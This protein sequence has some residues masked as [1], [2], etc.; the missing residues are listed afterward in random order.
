MV[1]LKG[2]MW[3]DGTEGR[4]LLVEPIQISHHRSCQHPEMLEESSRSPAFFLKE[5]PR[6]PAC[7][8]PKWKRRHGNRAKPITGFRN[9]PVI[10]LYPYLSSIPLARDGELTC[11]EQEEPF[12]D[13]AM[14]EDMSLSPKLQD[15]YRRWT[16]VWWP[17]KADWAARQ[18]LWFSVR[19]LWAL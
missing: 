13:W 17:S 1:G 9:K 4:K 14:P 3:G 6:S 18:T 19:G 16:E 5:S 10:G 15:V 2:R 8:I 11:A 12:R 7:S